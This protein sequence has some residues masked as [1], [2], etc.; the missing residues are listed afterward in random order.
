MTS[1]VLHDLRG[2]VHLNKTAAWKQLFRT[3]IIYFNFLVFLSDEYSDAPQEIRVWLFTF[4]MKN[5]QV[6]ILRTFFYLDQRIWLLDK[7]YN[8]I[9]STVCS[10]IEVSLFR[11]MKLFRVGENKKRRTKKRSERG[12]LYD[13]FSIVLFRA[14]SDWESSERNQSNT[15]SN[16]K[17][18]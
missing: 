11:R 16:Q 7:V 14:Y 18:F 3:I 5:L 6:L 1:S 10:L 4:A 8:S 12:K 2:T 9:L 17:K 15:T 13:L